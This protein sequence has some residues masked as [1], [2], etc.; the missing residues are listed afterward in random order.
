MPKRNY[1]LLMH[2]SKRHKNRS[3][4]GCLTASTTYLSNVVSENARY[5]STQVEENDCGPLQSMLDKSVDVSDDSSHDSSS[6]ESLP[7]L[8]SMEHDMTI[9]DEIAIHE[10]APPPIN[11]ELFSEQLSAWATNGNISHTNLNQLLHILRQHTCFSTLPIDSRTLLHTPRKYAIRTVPPG[12]YYHF[13]IEKGIVET[14]NNYKMK[15][16]IPN[17]FKFAD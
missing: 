13:G 17:T 12:F 5:L 3:I 10:F 8:E 16:N 6:Y 9:D 1:K 14:L 4:S 2:Q 11:G 15:E 7:R